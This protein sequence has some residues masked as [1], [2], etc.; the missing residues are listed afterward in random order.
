MIENIC[1][2]TKMVFSTTRWSWNDCCNIIST[3]CYKKIFIMLWIIYRVVFCFCINCPNDN[4][5]FFYSYRCIKI[6]PI[7]I[8]SSLRVAIWIVIFST[9]PNNENHLC[10]LLIKQ[11]KIGSVLSRSLKYTYSLWILVF[12]LF[13]LFFTTIINRVH[14]SFMRKIFSF[15][16]FSL[17]LINLSSNLLLKFNFKYSVSIIWWRNFILPVFI[18]IS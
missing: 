5:A 15:D 10:K 14:D 1:T 4:W 12:L 2:M 17:I 13:L 8:F 11:C 3:S 16:Q 7:Y 9:R 18:P 6:I